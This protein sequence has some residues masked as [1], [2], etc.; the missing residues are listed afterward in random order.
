MTAKSWISSFFFSTSCLRI[1][2]APREL[3]AGHQA[4]RQSTRATR[5]RVAPDSFYTARIGKRKKKE[6]GRA[7]RKNKGAS[8]SFSRV[9]K[10]TP[11]R[12][13][14]DRYRRARGKFRSRACEL[15]WNSIREPRP[16]R[17]ENSI[18]I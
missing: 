6:G 9:R 5:F 14:A 10:E 12:G 18:K 2:D 3:G 11:E 8:A 7:E 13:N 1:N 4:L 17:G 15:A 16:S